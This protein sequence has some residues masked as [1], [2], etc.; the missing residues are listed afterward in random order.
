MAG[1]PMP[2]NGD[3]VKST[4]SRCRES[5]TYVS[6]EDDH[7]H[8]GLCEDCYDDKQSLDFISPGRRRKL[9]R[10]AVAERDDLEIY[11]DGDTFRVYEVN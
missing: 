2:S 4:C 8:S 1:N 9:I 10:E 11:N 7:A 5:F 6:G 3:Q